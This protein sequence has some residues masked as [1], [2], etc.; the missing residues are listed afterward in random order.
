MTFERRRTASK[1]LGD[2]Y[3][4][5]IGLEYLIEMVRA[6]EDVLWVSFEAD[7]AGSLDDVYVGRTEGVEYIQAKYAVEPGEWSLEDLLEREDGPRAR[8]LLQKWVDSWRKVRSLGHAY[9]LTV[10][11]RRRPNSELAALFEGNTLST[12]ILDGESFGVEK[13]AVFGH[14]GEH[15]YEAADIRR[16]LGELRFDFEGVDVEAKRNDLKRAFLA[17]GAEEEN[18]LALLDA[19]RTWVRY[20]QPGSDGLVRLGDMRKAARLWSPEEVRLPQ[21]FPLDATIYILD[22]GRRRQVETLLEEAAGSMTLLRGAPGSGKSSFLSW[23]AGNPPMGVNHVFRHHCF[24]GLEDDTAGARLDADRAAL[25]LLAE[26]VTAA[27]ELISEPEKNNPAALERA[28]QEV[29][30]AVHADGGKVLI[31]LDGL[32]HVVREHDLEEARRLLNYLPSP[33]PEGLHILI[34]T[35]PVQDLL[36]PRFQRTPNTEVW[37]DG[38]SLEGT[39][40]YLMAHAQQHIDDTLVQA[41]HEKSDG[42]PLYLHYLV[43]A[44]VGAGEVLTDRAVARLPAYGGDIA[45]YYHALWNRPNSGP[46]SDREAGEAVRLLLA[47]LGWASF[48]LPRED[49]GYFARQLGVPVVQLSAALR[50]ATHLLDRRRLE[51]G[52]LRLYHESLRRFVREQDEAKTYRETALEAL[53]SWVKERADTATRWSAEWELEL[54]LGNPEPLLA[55]VTRDWAIAS[56]DAHRPHQRLLELSQLAVEV[57]AD[58]GD[59]AELLRRGWLLHYVGEATGHER[60]DAAGFHLSARVSNGM[61]RDELTN[62][63]ASKNVYGAQSLAAL[64]HAAFRDGSTEAPRQLLDMLEHQHRK[65]EAFLTTLFKLLAYAEIGPAGVLTYYITNLKHTKSTVRFNQDSPYRWRSGFRTY[66][67]TLTLTGQEEALRHVGEAEDLSLADRQTVYDAQLSLVVSEERVEDAVSFVNQGTRSAYGQCVAL[68]LGLTTLPPEGETLLRRDPAP[69]EVR[70]NDD[71]G[72]SSDHLQLVWS[73]VWWAAHGRHEALEAEAERLEGLGIHGCFLNYLI[74]LGMRVHASLETSSELDLSAV[75]AELQSLVHPKYPS[76][77]DYY[78]WRTGVDHLLEYLSRVSELTAL[79]NLKLCVRA[80]HMRAL[81]HSPIQLE[82]VLDWLVTKGHRWVPQE[83]QNAILEVLESWIMPMREHFSTR[84]QLLSRLAELAALFG[85][86]ERAE[87]LLRRGAANLLGYGF[88]KDAL[89]YEVMNALSAAH[90]AEYPDYERDLLR[91]AP[92]VD[93]MPEV[94]DGDETRGF[95]LDLHKG[96]RQAGSGTANKLALRYSAEE[97]VFSFD[98]A[99]AHMLG[100][101]APDDPVAHA[102]AHTLTSDI[103]AAKEFFGRRL[104][105]LRQNDVDSAPRAEAAYRRWLEV[106]C[107]P[108]LRGEPEVRQPERAYEGEPL[109]EKLERLTG[110]AD[111]LSLIQDEPS[112]VFDY[113]TSPWITHLILIWEA[114]RVK[115]NRSDAR[116]LARVFLSDERSR[117]RY[118]LYDALHTMLWRIGER[119]LAFEALVVAHSEAWGWSRYMTS[120]E[121]NSARIDLVLERFPGDFL[122]FIV[123]TARSGGAVMSTGRIVEALIRGGNRSLAFD[124]VRSFVDFATTLRADLNL[125]QPDWIEGPEVSDAIILF[126]RLAHTEIAVRERAAHAVADL[127][128][129]QPQ[130]CGALASWLCDQQQETR[131]YAGLLALTLASQRKHVPI[132]DVLPRLQ[133]HLRGMS[134]TAQLLFDVLSAN[135]GWARSPDRQPPSLLFNEPD[136]STPPEWFEKS[137]ANWPGFVEWLREIESTAP[138]LTVNVWRF[139]RT[140]GLTEGMVDES[141]QLLRRYVDYRKRFQSY[142]YPRARDVLESSLSLALT[143]RLQTAGVDDEAILLQLERPPVDPFLEQLEID[144]KPTWLPRPGKQER[145]LTTWSAQAESEVRAQ[146]TLD[147]VGDTI[148]SLDAGLVEGDGETLWRAEA[149]AFLH[150]TRGILPHAQD[151]WERLENLTAGSVAP[152]SWR[153][154]GEGDI[155][156]FPSDGSFIM[157]GLEVLPLVG[158]LRTQGGY[159]HQLALSTNMRIPLLDHGFFDDLIPVLSD[160]HLSYRDR[161]KNAERIRMSIWQD[162][163]LSRL[164]SGVAANNCGSFLSVDARYL[165]G[166]LD[167]SGWSL[168]WALSSRTQVRQGYQDELAEAKCFELINVSSIIRRF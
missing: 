30:A 54:L 118:D 96:L 103:G 2:D 128:S 146:L 116:T 89:L 138:G 106:E 18:W 117:V 65:D 37:V 122:T 94:T 114:D 149:I 31:I 90:T 141:N 168:G 124:I 101:A 81:L 32:D 60:R 91:I 132:A 123:R 119:Q 99:I 144:P 23:L 41:V 161:A 140:L 78:A 21:D 108:N 5:V 68:A 15:G 66:L 126:E 57:A 69:R 160:G 83:E 53:L 134:V 16:F 97:D 29:A 156:S 12:R 159:W 3:R 157:R 153:L 143:H 56:L 48:A 127:I 44:T 61:S 155:V 49:L 112:F 95:G 150:K 130:V 100:A 74:R 111:L 19:L 17:L 59:L 163:M 36:A 167:G 38:F 14:L 98:R 110:P 34:G 9:T 10:R 43:E 88:H 71:A 145:G 120:F 63:L 35:Q 24:L 13:A 50:D 142:I 154:G 82:R 45:A 11:T 162:G 1:N 135:A 109:P 158:T 147:K 75:I 136:M 70:Y 125:H 151:L 46:V 85:Q 121:A 42:N 77:D 7:D 39:A 33:A 4:D 40:A 25:A 26:V 27:R 76:E 115:V 165:N 64:A 8:S 104:S 55:G 166:R 84:A 62:I 58:A 105:Y 107:P 51:Q 20:K 79:K 139:A 92:L 137:L 131:T 6:P 164:F 86:A 113:S 22:Y 52:T 67:D 133:A 47:L 148:L 87:A 73:S 129:E 80:E 28:L 102:M 152:L 72:W 93:A